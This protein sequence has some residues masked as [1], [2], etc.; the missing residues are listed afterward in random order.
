MQVSYICPNFWNT[1]PNL[2]TSSYFLFFF[3]FHIDNAFISLIR[4]L[5]TIS[6]F[7]RI[8]I[9]TNVHLRIYKLEK[10]YEFYAF[11]ARIANHI[12]EQYFP[13]SWRNSWFLNETR[14]RSSERRGKGEDEWWKVAV[15]RYLVSSKTQSSSRQAPKPL[16]I[17]SFGSKL[18]VTE[19]LGSNLNAHNRIRY[20]GSTWRHFSGNT[21]C[22]PGS[23]ST[24]SQRVMPI[25]DT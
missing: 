19:P 5:L 3:F 10:S 11:N 7:S 22:T 1:T 2:L 17:I 16:V 13:P 15:F 23:V 12:D 25:C 6:C 8:L 4:L 20:A 21:A 24:R 14:K 9:C 18:P